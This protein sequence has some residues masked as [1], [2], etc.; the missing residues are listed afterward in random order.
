[1]GKEKIRSCHKYLHIL[2][3]PS[4][5]TVAS[6]SSGPNCAICS[7]ATKCKYDWVWNKI[8]ARFVEVLHSH[9]TPNLC[10]CVLR[11]TIAVLFLCHVKAQVL[12]RVPHH[13]TAQK[14]TVML[15]CVL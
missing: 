13:K 7:S 9:S 8:F 14:S 1:M 10:I 2:T 12:M 11:N 4:N 15:G 6:L 5:P 3:F